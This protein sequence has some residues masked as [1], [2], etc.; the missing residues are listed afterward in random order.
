MSEGLFDVVRVQGIPNL[1]Q[2]DT[3]RGPN[4]QS[5]SQGFELGPLK[6]ILVPLFLHVSDSM[7]LFFGDS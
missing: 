4:H 3:K 2:T 1:V 7:H 5:T 6:A